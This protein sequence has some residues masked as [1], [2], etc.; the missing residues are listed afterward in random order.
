[1]ISKGNKLTA[2]ILVMVL[3]FCAA[4]LAEPSVK[5]T[6]NGMA[7]SDAGAL[8]LADLM[9]RGTLME[10]VDPNFETDGSRMF[11]GIRLTEVL[12]L[13][14]L[15]NRHGLTVIGADQYVGYLTPERVAQGMLVWEMDG[16]PVSSLKGGPLKIEFPGSAGVHA[17]CFTWYVKGMVQGR[18]R[19]A[20]LRVTTG[21]R[22]KTYSFSQLA[23][24]SHP[25]SGRLVSIAQGCRNE[26]PEPATEKPARAVHLS[27]LA[28]D[29]P[30]KTSVTFLPYF[31]RSIGLKPEALAF[32]AQ[33]IVSC[34]GQTLHPALGGPYSVIFPLEAHTEL[35][36]SVPESG[37]FFFLKAIVVD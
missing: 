19:A 34:G 22:E 26:F 1:L 35:Q 11:K 4:A 37:A 3:M 13:A 36:E 15:D 6:G 9:P 33:I 32:G 20:G 31:G 27:E 25:L 8:A 17:S 30:G 14:G 10:T 24:M 21:A 7:W 18:P 16:G 29:L 28:G 5:V 23:A 12:S 2:G